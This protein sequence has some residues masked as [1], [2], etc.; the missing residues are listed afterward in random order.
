MFTL[1]CAG[2]LLTLEQ[3][4]VMGIVNATPDSFYEGHL[5]Q[6][7]G[8]MADL[9]AAMI[10]AGAAIIDVGGQSTRPGSVRL[11]PEEETDRVLPL[12]SAL[13]QRFPETVISIDTYHSKVAAA[14]VA[15]G[16][17]MINDISGGHLD[18]AML[19]TAGGLRVPYVCMHMKG[20]PDTMQQSPVYENVTLEVLD[21]FIERLAACKQAGITDIV[22]DPGFGFGKTTAHNFELLKNMDALRILGVP[23]LVGLSRKSMIYKTLGITPAEALNGTT[24][25]HMLALQN[26]ASLL[27]VHDVAPAMEAIRLWQTYNG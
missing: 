20:T 22:A 18:T 25:L 7:I 17:G 4:V 15:A 23:V 13:H 24:A 27:R 5:P 3:P 8:A 1:N 10:K 26:G 12:I 11:D 14:A 9:A 16:A 21:Y 19:A 6:G 2:R